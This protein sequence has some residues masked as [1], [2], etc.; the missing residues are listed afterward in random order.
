M[1]YQLPLDNIPTPAY[2]VDERLI[3]HNLET[4][5][6]IKKNT[7]CLIILALKAFSTYSVFPLISQYLDGSTASSLNEARLGFEKFGKEVHVYSP[8]YQTT[9]IDEVCKYASHLTFNSLLQL[10]RFYDYV[11][12]KYPQVQIGLRLNPEHS[13]TKIP[14]YD[15]CSKFSRLGVT[16]AEIKKSNF[17]FSKLDGFHFHTLCGKNAD[18]LERTVA[19]VEGKFASLFTKVSWINFGGGHGLTY[20]HYDHAKLYD[21]INGFKERNKCQVILEPGE[22]VVFQT[23]YL[24][25][26]VID[27]LKNERELAIIDS[28]ASAHMPDVLEM[29]YRPEIVGSGKADEKAFTYRLGGMTCLSGDEIGDYSFD[30]PLTLGQKLV[31][32]DM[33]HYTMVKNTYFNGVPVPSITRVDLEGK[34]HIERTFGYADFITQLGA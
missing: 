23:G 31:F 16:L 17:D 32:T 27:L 25:A 19:A 15:P 22:G 4:L 18:A 13:E 3:K 7:G 9:D 29:P 5:S 28:S 6:D 21:V 34:L 8:G 26:S 1:K 14:I 12:T 2:V 30:A 11:R 33:S 20:P 10:D 24:V